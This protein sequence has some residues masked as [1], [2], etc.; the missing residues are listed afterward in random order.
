M[1]TEVEFV[2]IELLNAQS[3]TPIEQ[4]PSALKVNDITSD[5]RGELGGKK[6]ND[7]IQ[8]GIQGKRSI[9]I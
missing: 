7:K 8:S 4:T 6:E 1:A 9:F 3:I 5:E 2:G